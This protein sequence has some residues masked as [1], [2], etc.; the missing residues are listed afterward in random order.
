M[1]DPHR[2]VRRVDRLSAGAGGTE[3]VDPEVLLG[4]LDLLLLG[5]LEERDHVEGREGG[6]PPL[7]GVEG[8]D[9]HESVDPTLRRQEP[10]G[11]RP[12]EHEGRRFDAGLLSGVD[13]VDLHP[14]ALL[15]RP[16]A[17]HPKEHVGPVLRFGAPR[18]RLQGRDRVVIVVRAREQGCQLDGLELP[19]ETV[20]P[21]LELLRE[22]RI[23]LVLE[24]L[25]HRFE[26][27][28]GGLETVVPVDPISEPSESLGQLLGPGLVVPQS[29]IGRLSRSSSPSCARLPSTS[30]ELLG[31]EDAVAELA[32]PFG[33]IA[34]ALDSR[35]AVS[36]PLRRHRV[37]DIT[38]TRC[39]RPPR[40]PVASPSPIG[41]VTKGRSY[42]HEHR[43]AP[44]G[45]R[46]ERDPGR[47]RTDGRDHRGHRTRLLAVVPDVRPGTPSPARRTGSLLRTSRSWSTERPACSASRDL[48]NERYP[49]LIGGRPGRRPDRPPLIPGLPGGTVPDSCTASGSRTRSS[50]DVTVDRCGPA[51]TRRTLPRTVASSAK[52]SSRG[53][54]RKGGAMSAQGGTLQRRGTIELPIWPVA[55][56]VVAALAA[57][58]GMTLLRD[59][60]QT[61][62]VTSVT[63]SERFANSTA[64]VRE[65][66][67]ARRSL[68]NVV[69]GAPRLASAT[70]DT[71]P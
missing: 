46:M 26:V 21:G 11:V 68:T 25:V 51:P 40:S 39:W 69:A 10:V 36:R 8:A 27:L 65:Q 61:R 45:V 6:V 56:L 7:L 66:G 30:K 29:R 54:E 55:V 1:R 32:E 17:V 16:S 12:V 18:A 28:E 22:L 47:E 59:T 37:T 35:G 34:H 13:L 24:Q 44:T 67:A 60:V 64:A 15:L 38:P 50:A 52:R 3:D 19:L 9:P 41:H 31:G 58:I 2:G 42:E 43:G 57:A 49:P 53:P 48:R 5:L 33:V 14:E 63:D 71:D 20:E 62:F 70:G 23:P 4:D